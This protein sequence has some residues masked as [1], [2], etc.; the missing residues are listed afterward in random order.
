MLRRMFGPSDTFKYATFFFF[1]GGGGREYVAAAPLPI[2]SR[3]H[4]QTLRKI[5]RIY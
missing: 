4:A 1:F 3:D 2:S 5:Q